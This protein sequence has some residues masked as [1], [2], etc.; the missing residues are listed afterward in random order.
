[1]G[2]L[3][4]APV[5]APASP[6]ET[7][8]PL[9][10]VLAS[11]RDEDG[12]VALGDYAVL[13]DGRSV[14][15]LARDGGV[16]WWALPRL[17]APPAFSALLGPAQG[18]R[19]ALRPSVP[20]ST[21]R[22]YLP[23]TNVVETTWTTD[24]GT[25]VVT[26]SLNC[27]VSGL[28]PWSELA[29]RV[30][31]VEGSVEL[32]LEVRPGD[33]L[34]RWQ[35]WTSDGP[36]GPLLHAGEMTLGVRVADP[37]SLEVSARHIGCRLVVE[38]GERA[39]VGVVG[40]SGRP[41]YLPDVDAVDARIELSTRRW[42][43][44]SAQ[45]DL[46]GGDV[47]GPDA[48]DRVGRSALALKLLLM[49][50]QGSVAAAATTS[51]PEQVGG[52][53]NWDYRYCWIRD[54]VFTVDALSACGLQEEV[55]AAVSWLLGT[56]RRHGP[57]LHVMY[58]LDG[59]LPGGEDTATVDGY[60]GSRPVRLGNGAAS[61]LQL[62]VFGDLFGT[63]SRWVRDGHVLDVSSARELTDL[64]DRCADT[65]LLDDAGIWELHDA[66]P[67]TS[68]KMNCWRALDAAA[69][70]AD[71]GHLAGPGRRWRTEADRVRRWVQENCWSDR[72]AAYTFFAGSDELDASVL[73]GARYGFD[74]GDRMS[75]TIDAVV[76][77]LGAGPLVYRYSGV[78]REEQTFVACAYWLVEALAAVGRVGEARTRMTRLDAV[79]N[80]LGLMAEMSVPD[81]FELTGNLP[82]A[83]SHLAHVNAAATFADR[84][85]TS[86]TTAPTTRTT[87]PTPS[88]GRR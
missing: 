82:Q 78:H 59:S 37:G 62:G 9:L 50:G 81:T 2:A 17:D 56:I 33:G 57:D 32:T 72:R 19:L 11:G 1:M 84:S 23:G 60:R 83:L 58:T 39:V 20:A 70:L 28:L 65:W 16:D 73:L 21:T 63:V 24:T 69:R 30:V 51:L 52:P 64:A 41:L 5:L 27:G 36:Q 68:S 26:A 87:T 43:E 8:P 35:P 14:A 85:G 55:H 86:G 49:T 77:E 48:L 66:R 12:Y 46:P 67:Y 53:K 3:D 44:W 18:G 42:R 54:A 29:F 61:Q 31:G 34:G 40:T 76:G 71:D 7:D 25:V 75:S 15:L 4:A 22:R 38:A 45:V 88:G 79:A 80:D 6:F 74:V 13:G 10:R 47:L